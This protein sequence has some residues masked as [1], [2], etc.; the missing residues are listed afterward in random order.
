MLQSAP[1]NQRRACRVPWTLTAIVPSQVQAFSLSLET[2]TRTFTSMSPIRHSWGVVSG[3]CV[4]RPHGDRQ[5][6]VKGR[7]P[8]FTSADLISSSVSHR[9]VYMSVSISNHCWVFSSR[10]KLRN[11][12][13]HQH[14]G[15]FSNTRGKRLLVVD[16]SIS[17]A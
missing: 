10:F 11:W 4:S 17:I 16:D 7:G 13:I 8:V 12:E 5:N 14:A 9:Y 1:A 2:A 3:C 6:K 15:P